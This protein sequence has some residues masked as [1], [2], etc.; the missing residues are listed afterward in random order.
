MA[1]L[2]SRVRARRSGVSKRRAHGPVGNEDIVCAMCTA[3]VD[4]CLLTRSSMRRLHLFA[5]L[6][7]IV[8]H[9]T[10]SAADWPQW[11][12]PRG[13]GASDEKNLP[14]RWSASENIAW[15]A[16]IGGVGVSSP[17]VSADR[18]FVT[19]QQGAGVRRPGSHPRL[20][21]GASAGV[22]GERALAGSIAGDRTFFVV[23]AFNRADGRRLWQ[24][25]SEAS[26]PLPGVHDKHNL[27]SPSPVSDGQM[28]YAWFGT[29]QIVALDMNGKLVWERHLGKEV[30][31]FDINWGHASSPTLFGDTLLLLCDHQPASYLLAVDKKTGRERW[32]ADRGR[33][34][35]SYTT[36][37]VVDTSTGPELIVNSSERVDAYDPRSGAFLWHVGGSNQ[38]PIP[39]PTFHDGVV[40]LTRGYRS[41]PFMAVRPGGRGDISRSHV[42]WEVPTGAPYISSLVYD[43]GILYMA[44]DVGAVTA[45]DAASGRRIWPQ[46]VDGIFSASPVAG[47]GQIYFVS[48]TGETI[49]VKAGRQPE[50]L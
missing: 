23:E 4:S 45:I 19:S 10:L 31:P 42:V 48:E 27:A 15:K 29:G 50:I 14:V 20:A 35:M 34:R 41:G 43:E 3:R 36:P 44:S 8:L 25:R 16:A 6:F 22:A 18:V 38:F 24:H 9:A 13:T 12:A 1:C 49:V 17:I 39:A 32:R 11:R 2:A 28:V 5:L 46:R 21:Q 7:A 37:F 47:D 40:Y 26:G 30:A 33:G